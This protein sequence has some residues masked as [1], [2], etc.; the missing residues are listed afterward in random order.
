[1]GPAQPDEV[2]L[3]ERLRSLP[4]VVDGCSQRGP[5]LLARGL[6]QCP[7]EIVGRDETLLTAAARR[8]QAGLGCEKVAAARSSASGSS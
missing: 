4:D 1:V 6:L 7:R 3:A 8:P 5:M 2:D